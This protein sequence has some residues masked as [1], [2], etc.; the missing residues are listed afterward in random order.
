M[1]AK[2]VRRR[3]VLAQGGVA[4]AAGL[5]LL[6]VPFPVWSFP[7]RPGEAVIP[8]VDQPPRRLNLSLRSCRNSCAGRRSM[9]G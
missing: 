8:W 6:N 1:E 3:E 9:P 4:A 7:S 5:T 2:D